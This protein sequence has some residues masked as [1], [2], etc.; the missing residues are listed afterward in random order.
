MADVTARKRRSGGR[1]GHAVRRGTA[2][3]EQLPWYSGQH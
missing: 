1:T 3:I 2:V